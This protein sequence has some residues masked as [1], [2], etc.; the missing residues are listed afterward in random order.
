M[1]THF[2]LLG[3]VFLNAFQ[4]A[5]AAG[6]GGVADEGVLGV[7]VAVAEDATGVGIA[8]NTAGVLEF[9]GIQCGGGAIGGF[10]LQITYNTAYIS[11]TLHACFVYKLGEVDG[12]AA[13]VGNVYISEDA[14]CVTAAGDI[15][16]VF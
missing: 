1:T 7:G 5:K 16:G 8:G 12:K 15:S 14:A 2:Y 3:L 13:T 6:G 9:C 11:L 10:L 4:I